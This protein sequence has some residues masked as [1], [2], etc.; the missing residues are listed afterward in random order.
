MLRVPRDSGGATQLADGHGAGDPP[1][2]A[3]RLLQHSPTAPAQV[4][5]V[6][7]VCDELL[8]LLSNGV[9]KWQRWTLECV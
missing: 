4:Q 9:L 8:P 5:Q 3:S 6:Q 1:T 7:G 2:G